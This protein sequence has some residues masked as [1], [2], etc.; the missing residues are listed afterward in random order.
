[1]PR[2]RVATATVKAT[3]PRCPDCGEP[4]SAHFGTQTDRWLLG[5]PW[6]APHEAFKSANW[7]S[8]ES[9]WDRWI[10]RGLYLSSRLYALLERLEVRGLDEAGGTAADRRRRAKDHKAWVDERAALLANAGVPPLPVGT[11]PREVSRRFKQYLRRVATDG[12][13]AADVRA[14]ERRLERKLPASAGSFFAAGGPTA[15]HDVDG[16]P[17]F[18][19]RVLPPDRWEADADRVRFAT[20]DHGDSFY[21]AAASAGDER[22]VLHYSHEADEFE[23]YADSFAACILRFAASE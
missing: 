14:A 20:T 17:G 9:G 7:S 4:R 21:L 8:S 11:V 12:A 5:V 6:D 22:P 19:A 3:I 16:Q 10:D 1:M 18:T 2:A 15:F 13:P 23:P